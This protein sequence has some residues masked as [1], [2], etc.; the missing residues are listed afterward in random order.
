MCVKIRKLTTAIA[1]IAYASRI[2]K[3]INKMA[4]VTLIVAG[5]IKFFHKSLT[6]EPC[7]EI[8]GQMAISSKSPNIIGDITVLKNG[9]PT[10]TFCPVKASLISEKIVPQNT[11][12]VP[13]TK[14]KLFN[15]K[16][17]SFEIKDSICPDCC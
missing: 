9:T 10:V 11:A 15:K 14:I 2:P 1:I 4:I 13:P 12:K 8:A 6:V 17:L 7:Q 3:T 5:N 16:E